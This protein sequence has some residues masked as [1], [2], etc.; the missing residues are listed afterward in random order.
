VITVKVV[1]PFTLKNTNSAG[2][3][4]VPE[5]TT[6]NGLLRRVGAPLLAYALPA[7]VNGSHVRKNQ[8]LKEGDL[9]VFI[10]PISGG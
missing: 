10:L 6:L 1:A 3:I 7:A 8:R 2:E 9:V 5:R 4:Q